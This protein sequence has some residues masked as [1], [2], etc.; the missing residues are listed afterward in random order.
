[1]LVC[2]PVTGEAS[3]PVLRVGADTSI[4]LQAQF[5]FAYLSPNVSPSIDPELKRGKNKGH[6]DTT[7]S[8]GS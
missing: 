5:T 6:V 2:L 3:C 8:P 4:C 1:M 7:K